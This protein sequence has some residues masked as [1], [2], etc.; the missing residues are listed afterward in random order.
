MI[1]YACNVQLSFLRYTAMYLIDIP[2]DLILT[3]ISSIKLLLITWISLRTVR[4]ETLTC[5]AISLELMC[6][7]GFLI[8]TG[9][10]LSVYQAFNMYLLSK[11]SV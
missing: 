7:D 3:M 2:L 11:F 6:F 9:V 1:E 8:K 10:V 4:F 5:S